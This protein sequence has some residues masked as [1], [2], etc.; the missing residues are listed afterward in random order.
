[1]NVD[2]SKIPDDVQP[3]E[4]VRI[5]GFVNL[6]GRVFG[7]DS[8]IGPFVEIQRTASIGQRVQLQSHSL[9]CSGVDIA[10]EAFIGHGVMLPNDRLPRATNDNG[11][12][13]SPDD[14]V[15]VPTKLGKCAS[16]QGITHGWKEI[17]P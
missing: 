4:N 14:W 17:H 11:T 2:F 8:F 1:M 6:F 10:D 9:I 16:E 15:C 7:D 12:L 5:A 3:G 13:K